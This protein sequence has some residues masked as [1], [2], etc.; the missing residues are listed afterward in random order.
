[1]RKLSWA[2]LLAGTMGGAAPAAWA[3][4]TIKIGVIQP[5]TGSVAYN[6]LTYVNGAKLAVER[7]N[8]AGGV[9]GK[10]IELVIEDGQC[11]PAN[12]VNAAEKL[13]VRDKVV[14]L[15]GAFCSSA[16]AAVMPVAE[17][18]KLPMLTG[19]SSKADLTEKGLQYFFRS[20]E[21]DRLM[22][23]TFSKILAQKLQLKTVA[24]IGVNDDWGRGGV[25]DFS[26]DLSALGV[27]T[28]MKEYF[29]H[30]ATDFYTLLTKLRAAKPD[31]VF[32]AAETQDGSIL[33]KQFKEFGIQTKIFGVGSWAT[34]DFIGLTG[35]ASEGIYAAVPYASSMPGERNQS[36]VQYYSAA[37]KEKPGKYGAAGYNAL[38]IVMEAIARA[39]NT[40]ADAIR[41]ALR[42]TDYAAPNGHFKFT[43]KGEGYGFD[44]VLVQIQNREPKVVAQSPTERP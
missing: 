12:S 16:T 18:Y 10:K 26:K 23:R 6:G 11:R 25:E 24:Y 36:F 44:V 21:T 9:L 39:G 7:R 8:A 34:S 3:Q 19:V 41:D 40:Q 14:A 29:D 37:Y 32:V 22:S 38:N 15:T 42:K 13:I 33:V 4:E 1:M 17:K 27:K 31:G 30:G 20:A 35:D 2:L 28:V 43:E 5:L